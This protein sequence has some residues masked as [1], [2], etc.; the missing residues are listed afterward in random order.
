MAVML[1]PGTT[2]DEFTIGECVHDGGMGFIY[3]VSGPDAGFPMIMKVPR[4]GHGQP[5]E[6]VVG[7]EV[8]QM[9]LSAIASPV[10]AALRRRR[11]PG[12]C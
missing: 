9:M 6:G 7:F 2:I 4:L 5:T 12:R 10:R 8:E 11:R 3:R 1:K